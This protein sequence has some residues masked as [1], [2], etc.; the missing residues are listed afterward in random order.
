M[1][2]MRNIP[3]WELQSWES[4]T[5]SGKKVVVKLFELLKD[6]VIKTNIDFFEAMRLT[7]GFTIVQTEESAHEIT[8]EYDKEDEDEVQDTLKSLQEHSTQMLYETGMKDKYYALDQRITN[9]EN[10]LKDKDEVKI[11]INGQEIANSTGKRL[12]ADQEV[13]D[14]VLKRMRWDA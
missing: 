2:K 6:P 3:D 13:R 4:A 9:L 14:I 1:N 10:K 12:V 7:K 5:K 8:F 11:E